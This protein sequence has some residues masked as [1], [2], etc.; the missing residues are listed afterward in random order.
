[1]T[2]YRCR[3]CDHTFE[4]EE[5]RCPRC[6]R[7]STVEPARAPIPSVS[8]DARHLRTNQILQ[9]VL[10]A[11][12]VLVILSVLINLGLAIASLGGH[13]SLSQVPPDATGRF[14]FF[15]TVA[16]I[17]TWA[18]L[19]L[20]W[21]ALNTWGLAKRRPWA[22][23]STRAYWACSLLTCA[24]IPLGLYGLVSLGRPGVRALFEMPAG[25]A[26]L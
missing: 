11:L 26:D 19:G 24:C 1:M 14:A 2:P 18:S 21:A 25:G 13:G 16:C 20:P 17:G 5:A 7:T 23:R 9:A 10:V 8:K 15:G 12:H 6:L 22:L 4:S 3:T